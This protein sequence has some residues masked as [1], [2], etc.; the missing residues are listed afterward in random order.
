MNAV[1][2]RVGIDVGGT[3]LRLLA[4]SSNGDR[5]EVVTIPTA[6]DY[7]GLLVQIDS[8]LRSVVAGPLLSIGCGIC[9]VADDKRPV[10]VP[11]LPFIERRPLADD[12][13]DRFGA[14]VVLGMDGHYTLLAEAREGA[15]I[16]YSSVVLVAVGTGI[17]GA[18]MLAGKIWRGARGS[19]GSF[20]WL[21]AVGGKD[22]AEHGLFEQV[23]SG[24]ALSKVASAYRPRWRGE[25]LVAAA[26]SGD[27]DAA[28]LA[29]RF[30]EGL[31]R[32]LA[33][34][35]SV[36]DPELIILAGGLS[37][38]IDVFGSSIDR[39]M[40]ERASPNG[41]HVPVRAAVLGSQAGVIGALLATKVD[42]EIWL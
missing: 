7:G 8:L 30:G 17:G 11:A 20:G 28:V 3:S 23:A 21:S 2:W 27:A 4:E 29:D 5:S 35:A 40:V 6:R 24:T 9:G 14:H 41:R 10:F 15:G 33:A 22:D 37:E 18:I 26:R 38:A 1:G 19:A 42:E 25:D 13:A 16:G 31:G 12:L 34:A 32:G 36:L 39:A